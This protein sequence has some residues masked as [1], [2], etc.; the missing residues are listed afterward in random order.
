MKENDKIAN[1]TY[2]KLSLKFK[3]MFSVTILRYFTYLDVTS[4]LFGL[5]FFLGSFITEDNAINF[6]SV[7]KF[8]LFT[9]AAIVLIVLQKEDSFDITGDK[10]SLFCSI[11]ISKKTIRKLDMKIEFLSIIK[12]VLLFQI[13]FVIYGTIQF[14]FLFLLIS[15]FQII[16]LSI[17]TYFINDVLKLL[18]ILIGTKF[19]LIYKAKKYF[20]TIL[21]TVI[22]YVV[23]HNVDIIVSYKYLF[24]NIISGISNFNSTYSINL[25]Y[26][27]IVL[28]V[29]LII[30]GIDYFLFTNISFEKLSKNLKQDD[31]DFVPS[32]KKSYQGDSINGIINSLVINDKTLGTAY[33]EKILYVYSGMAWKILIL[34]L[35][36]VYSSIK[37]VIIIASFMAL[38]LCG[39]QIL[40]FLY[41]SS[42]QVLEYFKIFPSY[43]DENISK[44]AA[45]KVLRNTS[46]YV[47]LPIIVIIVVITHN[48]IMEM[49]TTIFTGISIYLGSIYINYK[50]LLKYKPF[51]YSQFSE[52]KPDEGI[53]NIFYFSLYMYILIGLAFFDFS[54]LTTL[55]ILIVFIVPAFLSIVQLLKKVENNMYPFIKQKEFNDCGVA[56]MK[57]YAEYYQKETLKNWELQ[58]GPNKA[59]GSSFKDISDMG[60]QISLDLIGYEIDSIDNI[61]GKEKVHPFIAQIIIKK[62][63]HFIIVYETQEK[64]L[65]IG[66]PSKRSLSTISKTSFEKNFSG[67]ILTKKQ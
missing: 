43:S 21:L 57:M 18:I 53:P 66:D 3:S 62:R 15:F 25:N 2:I 61:I 60:K 26:I 56:C 46:V 44:K 11:P 1:A 45:L 48:N 65:I 10:N 5:L 37:E 12:N 33:L 17:F 36:G 63:T 30:A 24:T 59:Y 35:S 55:P 47:L 16:C 4:I 54:T 13:V 38:Y 67:Y 51:Y 20:L 28:I 49:L 8:N 42:P 19:T 6:N 7:C 64:A 27:F 23:N 22:F 39:K 29:S 14:G 41:S 32:I 31:I 58:Y 50:Y 9:V 40:A 34:Y 52:S